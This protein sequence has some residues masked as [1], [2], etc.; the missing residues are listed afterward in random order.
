MDTKRR[1]SVCVGVESDATV[2][3]LLRSHQP[4]GRWLFSKVHFNCLIRRSEQSVGGR[5]PY[6]SLPDLTA[7]N[8]QASVKLQS[9]ERILVF[10]M[11]RTVFPQL[12]RGKTVKL[13]FAPT[14]HP[15]DIGYRFNY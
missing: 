14:V 15:I 6:S 4:R 3:S 2:G 13:Q 1:V 8:S 10:A 12:F 11:P 9:G 7:H 5:R